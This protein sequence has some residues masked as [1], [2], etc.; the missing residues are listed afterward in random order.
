MQIFAKCAIFR[1]RIERIALDQKD[2]NQNNHLK[3]S[4]CKNSY[5][6]FKAISLP[7]A[8]EPLRLISFQTWNIVCHQVFLESKVTEFWTGPRTYFYMSIIDMFFNVF[9]IL[10]VCGVT[11]FQSKKSCLHFFLISFDRIKQKL[12]IEFWNY[13]ELVLE[14][15][16]ALNKMFYQC[17]WL[18][19]DT[20]CNN[21]HALT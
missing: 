8:T 20:C 9:L 2:K 6:I 16:K 18:A 13:S 17:K 3:I 21:L 14:H 15:I 1:W 19:S 4:K 11:M 12:K 7:K 5:R 10:L